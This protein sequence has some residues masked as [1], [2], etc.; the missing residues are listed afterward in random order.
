MVNHSSFDQFHLSLLEKFIPNRRNV[1]LR[2]ERYESVQF[3]SE[4]LSTYVHCVQDAA[5]IFRIHDSEEQVVA[6]I[7]EGLT[8]AQ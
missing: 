6:R 1:Q 4:P 8:Q 2:F 5:L 7:V 3:N